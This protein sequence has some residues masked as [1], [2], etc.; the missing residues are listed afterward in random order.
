MAWSGG[1]WTQRPPD[2]SKCSVDE[3]HQERRLASKLMFVFMSF[4]TGHP[5]FAFIAMACAES[6]RCSGSNRRGKRSTSCQPTP[7][8]MAISSTTSSDDSKNLPSG[9]R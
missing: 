1:T 5:A 2:F 7:S 9:A 6:G 3:T 4:E 8:F